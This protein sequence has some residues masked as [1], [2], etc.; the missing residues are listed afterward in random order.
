MYLDLR[1]CFVFCAAELSWP[2][3]LETHRKTFGIDRRKHTLYISVIG[4]L[5]QRKDQIAFL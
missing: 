1:G 3:S 4:A 5:W 2:K